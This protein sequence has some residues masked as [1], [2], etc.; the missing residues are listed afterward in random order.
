M[1]APFIPLSNWSITVPQDP[2]VMRKTGMSDHSPIIASVAVRESCK[3]AL[4]IPPEIFNHFAFPII[5]KHMYWEDRL[6]LLSGF[7]K[8]S[9]VK[10]YIRNAAELTRQYI[11]D[12]PN[13]SQSGFA[14][15]STLSTIARLVWRQDV[16]LAL[17]ITGRDSF[18]ATH[19]AITVSYTHLTLPTIYSV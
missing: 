18:V 19:V 9:F 4:P 8:L 10:A 16:Q 17:A 14:K 2:K 6:D 12:N 3:E 15:L 13:E 7:E 1:P 5:Y 11:Q